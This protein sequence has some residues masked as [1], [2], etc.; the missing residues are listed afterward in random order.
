MAQR[1][2]YLARALAFVL[3]LGFALAASQLQFDRGHWLPPHHPEQQKLDQ[4]AESFSPGE[5]LVIAF[6][7][8]T[9]FFQPQPMAQLRQLETSLETSLGDLLLDSLSPLSAQHILDTGTGLEIAAYD[10]LLER[11]LIDSPQSFAQIFAESPYGGRLA[12]DD[13]KA[14]ALRLRLNSRDEPERRNAALAIIKKELAAHPFARA[15][16][17]TGEPVIKAKLQRESE[18]GLPPLLLLATAVLVLMGFLLLRRRPVIMAA[19]ASSFL[20][21]S[22][23]LALMVLLGHDVNPIALMLPVMLA[24]IAFADALHVAAHVEKQGNVLGGL[25][26]AALPCFLASL[27]SAVG[28]GAFILSDIIPLQQF[29]QTAI[30]AILMAFPLTLLACFAFLSLNAQSENKEGDNAFQIATWVAHRSIRFRRAM[31]GVLTLV[32]LGLAIGLIA[33]R[34]ETNFLSVFF[35]P[36]S[37]IR[38]DFRFVDERLGGS[39]GMDI[40]LHADKDNLFNQWDGFLAH[41]QERIRLSQLP[42]V[43]FVESYELALHE[44]YRGFAGETGLPNNEAELAQLLLF[45][46]LSR[47]ENRDDVLSPYAGFL[48]DKTRLYL[49][50]PDLSSHALAEQIALIEET[51]PQGFASREITG[52][53]AFIHALSE[54]VL[55]T[56]RDSFALT[57]ALIA[58][59]FLLQFGWRLGLYGMMANILPVGALAGLIAL[60]GV[61]FDFGTVL[62]AGITLGMA[63]DDAVHFLHAYRRQP[64]LPQVLTLVGKPI[65]FTSL[66][67]C[68]GL[69]VL[70]ISPLA[71]LDR[72]ALFAIIGL[73]FSLIA[74]LVLLPAWLG[75]KGHH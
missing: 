28:F 37:E 4:L 9:S 53:G 51:S 18:T 67:F 23:A 68:A 35:Y 57:L 44:A 50:L 32:L 17:L 54:E 41:Q 1:L 46:E 63:V 39:G 61:P 25:N 43:H 7:V 59:L 20:A 65:V 52:F 31:G 6:E 19:L 70:F 36:Q 58:F 2:T 62:I 38:Q 15:A 60:L 69:A 13:G 3:A 34:T 42:Q 5:V 33:L 74:C 27:T 22:C 24:V 10:E 75:T 71:V 55:T 29:G 48:Y 66:V 47:S 30:V 21:S 40:I 8:G 72:F 64:D 45:L 11:G 49:R 56:Q 12:A 14:F 73:V 26:A 16:R